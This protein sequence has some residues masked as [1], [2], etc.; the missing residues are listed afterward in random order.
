[1][2]SEAGIHPI[3]WTRFPNAPI[4][5]AVLDIRVELPSDVGLQQLSPYHDSIQD[6]YPQKRERVHWQA[7]FGNQKGV[8]ESRGPKAE[9]D[10]YLYTSADGKNIVQVRLDGFTLSRLQPYD[11]WQT[12][13]EE[14]KRL[15]QRYLM[16]ATPTS[17][18]RLALRYINC[19]ELPL[20]LRDFKDYLI[21]TPEI[22]PSL[23]QGL[24][25]FFMRLEIPN[26]RYN[27]IA[28]VTETIEPP[29]E[30]SLPFILDIDVIREA[31]YEPASTEIW[32]TFEQL[33][34][35]KNEIFFHSVTDKAKELFQ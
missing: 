8:A 5:E 9:V 30:K 27:A 12:F 1:M 24:K 14:A 21:T 31:K 16:I 15:W 32:D 4:R 6:R 33:R 22:A 25:T 11:R 23:P 20:P 3:N 2:Q 13:R 26:D 35:F 28:I 34:N 19:L 7:E 10:G 18:T 17:V 29:H